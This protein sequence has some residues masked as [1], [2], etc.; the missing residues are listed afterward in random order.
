MAM[1]PTAAEIV[2]IVDVATL[3]DWASVDNTAPTV[4]SGQPMCLLLP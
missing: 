3:L 2:A 4:A 1:E